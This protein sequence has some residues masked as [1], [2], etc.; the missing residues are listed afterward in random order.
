MCVIYCWVLDNKAWREM[1]CEPMCS[2]RFVKFGMNGWRRE[3]FGF[4]LDLVS[5]TV[6]FAMFLSSWGNGFFLSFQWPMHS[7]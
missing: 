2:W 3:C 7:C 5:V 1:M 4:P 6:L